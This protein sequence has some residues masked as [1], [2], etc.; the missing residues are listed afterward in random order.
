MQSIEIK[1]KSICLN[2]QTLEVR[3]ISENKNFKDAELDT[4]FDKCDEPS[5]DKSI[6]YTWMTIP[7]YKVIKKD[8]K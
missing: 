7:Y 4:Y 1:Y 5:P 6:A 2:N 8:D 3:L